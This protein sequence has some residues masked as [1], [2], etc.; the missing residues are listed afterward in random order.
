MR[1]RQ[2]CSL[3][4]L[5]FFIGLTTI[6][7]RRPSSVAVSTSSAP[8]TDDGLAPPKIVA[9]HP[10]HK[11]IAESESELDATLMKQSKTLE[12]AV[13][14]YERRYKVSPPPKFDVWYKM[15][16]DRH[17]QMIDE[18]DTI[19][20][21]LLPF[22]ALSPSTI[23][24][25]AREA[26]G[27]DNAMVGLLIR[28]GSVVKMAGGDEEGWQRNSTKDMM[29]PFVKHLPDMDLA[30]NRH[31]EARVIVAHDDL[32]RLVHKAV[33][34]ALPSALAQ[35]SSKNAWSPRPKD[36]DDGTQFPEVRITRFNRFA[37]QPTWSHSRT[38][39]SPE[40]PSRALDESTPDETTAY[41]THPLGFI[42]N[43]TAFSDICLSPSL[44]RTFGFF[45][46][47]NAFDIVQDLFPIFSQSKPS[48]FQDILYPSPWY[49]SDKAPYV[50]KEDR[51]WKVKAD[52]LYWRGSTTGGFSRDGG[53]RRQH[54]QR[55][56]QRIN[57]LDTAQVL[58]AQKSSDGTD[59]WRV[60]NIQRPDLKHLFNV[61]FSYVGQ[62]DPGDCDAQRE[63][64]DIAPG[65]PR[66]EA[67][68][69]KHVLDIDGN[70]F[71]G[72]FYAFLKSKSLVFKMAIFREWHDEWI[73]PW[74]HYIPLS[75][76]G[77]EYAEVMRYFN[78]EKEEGGEAQRIANAGRNWS[79][80]ALRKEDYEVWFFRLL[81]EY[82]R[83]VD[84]DRER[85]GYRV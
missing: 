54:R 52:Q 51:E 80:R 5:V 56:V 14:E 81:L 68:Q 40:S 39:C 11:L 35:Q 3:L 47:P 84:D 10:V 77:D 72:R 38:S 13:R 1:A 7:L 8:V 27:F 32:S 34:E 59:E 19:Y 29:R 50:P 26:L 25:R 37:H 71:S 57:A 62:C 22:W 4:A 21:A 64:F 42:Y 55:I 58:E 75:L 43:H 65:A 6:I 46:R 24:E 79:T 49:W 31:D 16:K 9:L 23:R 53:W 82:G 36:L 67:F 45:D 63:F 74:A 48:S 73:R 44:Q 76:K 78:S 41:A 60:K 12:E 85:I 69:Y 83:L 2:L 17:V 18:Y 66:E 20:H 70:A 28:D 15:A 61:S 30:F 33:D